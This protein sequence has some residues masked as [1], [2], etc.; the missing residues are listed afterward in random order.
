M[1][2]T[3][4]TA[5]SVLVTLE[6]VLA[7]AN[8]RIAVLE[9]AQRPEQRKIQ[10]NEL[11]ELQD[12]AWLATILTEVE[13]EI[14]RVKKVA[15]FNWAIGQTDTTRITRKTTELSE[16]L[17][18]GTMRDAFAAEV[19]ALGLADRRIELV[20]DQSS[21]GTT[22]F[23]VALVRNPNE[24]VGRVLSEG[25]HRCIALAA[26]L[27]ELSTEN[28]AS[29]LVFEDPVS[30]LDHNYRDVVAS[31]L[32]SE[33]ATGRQLIIFTHDIGFFML[34][35]E[36]AREKQVPTHYQTIN[37]TAESAGICESGNPAKTQSVPTLL[38][39]CRA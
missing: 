1:V 14:E 38:A 33:A 15:A 18:T 12:R 24:K 8:R 2:P 29:G 21:Y 30:S 32:I 28:S 35:D 20:Q 31:R 7:A 26:F 16:T 13:Q 11:H 39:A 4:P 3:A 6:D 5:Q 17:V 25:E 34:L 19:N 9:K 37:R 22:R 36:L 23:K 27:A 10:E